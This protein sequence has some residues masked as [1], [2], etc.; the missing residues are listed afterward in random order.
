MISRY[1]VILHDL[2]K[3]YLHI[4]VHNSILQEVFGFENR[5]IKIGGSR[6][7]IRGSHKSDDWLSF[8]GPMALICRTGG[9]KCV[10]ISILDTERLS[11]NILFSIS[12][13]LFSIGRFDASNLLLY[14]L[15]YLLVFYPFV[16][17]CL[18]ALLFQ[19]VHTLLPSLFGFFVLLL[20]SFN[21]VF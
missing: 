20:F 6:R 14:L 17:S 7:R 8:V 15:F 3:M 5:F 2:L 18:S 4:A 13:F 9:S 11:L 10:G 1:L 12:L 19:L 16:S 21:F